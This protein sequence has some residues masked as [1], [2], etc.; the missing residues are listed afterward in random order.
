MYLAVTS[1]KPSSDPSLSGSQLADSVPKA[2]PSADV[3]KARR[4]VSSGSHAG[5]STPCSR[6]SASYPLSSDTPDAM[7]TPTKNRIR[8]RMRSNTGCGTSSSS[9][10][11]PPPPLMPFSSLLL[12]LDFASDE[13]DSSIMSSCC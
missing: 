13:E 5:T 9:S 10:S 6:L 1:S 8:R 2:I 12:P 4:M 3:P 11:P 7:G